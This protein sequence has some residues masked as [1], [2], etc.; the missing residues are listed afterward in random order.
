M[1]QV[2]I[3]NVRFAPQ[4]WWFRTI[5]EKWKKYTSK[6]TLDC[7]TNHTIQ[8]CW[9][10]IKFLNVRTTP[11]HKDKQA[12]P[13]CDV[14]LPVRKQSGCAPVHGRGEPLVN[15]RISAEECRIGSGG[16][17]SKLNFSPEYSNVIFIGFI[18]WSDISSLFDLL[19]I[20]DDSINA[21]VY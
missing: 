9:I 17:S 20:E 18:R 4:F 15:V 14:T 12:L 10:S 7:C 11:S 13:W 19:K 1:F 5:S 16:L 2:R 3:V 8:H 6:Y 21:S